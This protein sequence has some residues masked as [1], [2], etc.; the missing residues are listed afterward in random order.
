ILSKFSPLEWRGLSSV[1]TTLDYSLQER[2][3]ILL[4][5]YLRSVENRGISNGAAVVVDNAT[6]EVLSLV[7]SKDFFDELH[8][9]QV[10]GALALRQ[11]GSTLKPFTYA[12]ALERGLTAA[13]LIDD[14]PAQSAIEADYMPQNYD[15]KY[16]GRMSLRAALAC[17]Y[18]IP[19]VAVLQAVG[20]DLL[21]QRLKA[22]GFES[23][24]QNPSYYGIG[25]TLGNGEVGLLE[26]VVAY[27]ALA[28]QGLFT[29]GRSILGLERNNAEEGSK[30]PISPTPRCVFSPQVAYIITHI[31]ADRDARVPSFGYHTP[32]SFPFPVAAKTGTSRDFRDNWVVGFS[33]KYTVGVWVG[34]FDG[35]PMHNV[36]GI[37]GCGPLFRDIMLCLHERGT[38][39]DFPQPEGI[40]R[41]AV[42]PLSGEQATSSC[43]GT[44]EEIF[45]R[46]TEP[47]GRC[48][49]HSQ[50]NINLLA[51]EGVGRKEATARFEIS[52]PPS[53]AIFK[54]DPILR[55]EHQRLKLRASVP[56]GTRVEKVEWWIDEKKL[57]EAP[58]PYS[59]FW[60][61]RPGTYTIK[62]KALSGSQMIESLPVK[63][64]VLT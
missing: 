63:I 10:N 54:L 53:G 28:R 36:S 16:H 45:I 21:Y 19:A 38:W 55:Q 11:P 52:F 15:R 61:L 35:K 58:S 14:S 22:L 1:T 59:I 2:V 40:V 46:G 3:E 57:G 60:N 25:L 30:A 26:L 24:K 17:S 48:F 7:G 5:N 12:L 47:R 9:G 50:E 33:P 64:S 31:L 20:S 42:C 6:G 13:T 27:A 44:I 8:D 18:N 29:A 4:R 34:N 23:L 41:L 43:P 49:R 37:T 51:Y 39:G 32:L 62:A 56:P